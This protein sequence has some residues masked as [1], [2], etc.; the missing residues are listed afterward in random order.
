MKSISDTLDISTKY[1]CC[2]ETA[3]FINNLQNVVYAMS[4]S[5]NMISGVSSKTLPGTS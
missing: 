4:Y 2:Q 1:V 5:P 3:Q